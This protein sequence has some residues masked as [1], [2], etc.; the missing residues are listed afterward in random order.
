MHAY[1][2]IAVNAARVAGNLLCRALNDLEQVQMSSKNLND[3]VTSA[4]KAAEKA[5]C[6][7]IHEYYP[8]HKIL[9][10]E[11]GFSGNQES[12]VEWIIDPLDGTTNF[13]HGIPHFAISIAVRVKNRVEHAVIYDPVREE[14]FTA[15]RGE[16]ARLNNVRIRIGKQ[17]T[18]EGSLLATGFPFKDHSK[19]DLWQQTFGALFLSCSDVRRAGSAALDLAYLAAGRLDGFWEFG[20]QPWDIAAGALLVSEA[21]GIVE[22]LHG[23]PDYLNSGNIIAANP[24]IFKA[25]LQ[26]LNPILKK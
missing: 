9:A 15:S 8:D 22:D 25:M 23:K 5:I 26:K 24:K 18:L 16:G 11:S 2:N 10:E 12:E 3:Y 19:L 13:I 6:K 4:D 7:I 17:K 14:L 20:L 21:G 1:V